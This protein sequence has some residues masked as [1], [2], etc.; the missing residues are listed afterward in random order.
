V[1]TTLTE[2]STV[3]D[4]VVS[5]LWIAAD[6]QLKVLVRFHIHIS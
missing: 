2:L 1:T 5:P 3:S 6:R 4:D